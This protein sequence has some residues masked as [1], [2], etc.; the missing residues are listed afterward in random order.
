MEAVTRMVADRPVVIFSRTTCCMSHTIKTLI[1]GFGANPTVYELD[2]I[3]D[4]QQVERALQ[5]MGCKPSIPAVFI[6]Q[7]LIG[8]PNQIMTLQ[9][10]NQLVPM[11]M[12]AGAIWI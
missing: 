4:G 8:G 11:L 1:S 9:V 6:G 5:Q 12:R 2:E 3:Q 7:Q 10:K